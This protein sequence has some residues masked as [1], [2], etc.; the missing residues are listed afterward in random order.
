M[1][2]RNY[3]IE[4]D[5]STGMAELERHLVLDADHFVD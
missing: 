4:L 2:C 5:I 1:S 3:N